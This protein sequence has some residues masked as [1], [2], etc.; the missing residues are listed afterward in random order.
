MTRITIGLAVAA[1][2]IVPSIPATARDR[3]HDIEVTSPSANQ[4]VRTATVRYADLNLRN[5]AGVDQLTLRV[6]TAVKDVCEPRNYSDLAQFKSSRVCR[7]NSME[8]ANADIALAVARAEKGDRS[9]AMEPLR[10]NVRS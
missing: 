2:L 1:V 8:R 3:S 9:A 6:K 7:Y 4:P 5:E 10:I